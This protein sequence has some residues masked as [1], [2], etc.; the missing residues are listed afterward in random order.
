VWRE[1]LRFL[2]TSTF[3]DPWVDACRSLVLLDIQCWP[4]TV[5]RHAWSWPTDR[6][7]WMAPSLDLYAAFHHP[8]PGEAWLLADGHA[9][10]AADGLVGW[11]GRLWTAGGT[12]VASGGGQLL[13][14]RVSGTTP[15]GSPAPTVPPGSTP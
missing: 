4:A 9:P 11:T 15:A 10:V 2:P 14:R 5:P 12:L 13:C 3:A 1:W 7:T 6:I 8:C